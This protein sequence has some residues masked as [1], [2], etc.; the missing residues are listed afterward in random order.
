MITCAITGSNGVLGKRL[1]KI[2]PY[3]FYEFKKDIRNINNVEEWVSKKDFDIVIHLAAL[4]SV[5]KVNKNY[6]KAHDINVK[7]TLNLMKSIINKKNKPKWI[8][9]SS[10]SH[11]YKPTFKYKKINEKDKPNPQNKYGKTKLSAENYLK[12]KAKKNSIKI[13][14]GRIFSFTDIFQKPPYVIPSILR[15]IKSAKKKIILKNLNN[16]RDFLNT[17]D[18]VHAI[19]TLRKN[20][21]SGTYN[22]GSGIN[23]DL[24]GIAR[25]FA[26]KYKKRISFRDSKKC[27]YLIANNTKIKKLGWTSSKYNENIDY[28]YK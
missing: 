7:G 26:I 9:F 10:T 23:F 25:I 11:V 27:T 22:I 1:K 21:A 15:K 17:K 6:K 28:F 24:R 2:L 4:V 18:I 12:K 8:F 16:Y 20:E 19:D 13:C 5:N 14:I 3:K